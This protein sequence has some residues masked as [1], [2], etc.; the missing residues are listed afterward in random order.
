VHCW[1]ADF[2]DNSVLSQLNSTSTQ[3]QTNQLISNLIYVKKSDLTNPQNVL[4][5]TLP[6]PI[7]RIDLKSTLLDVT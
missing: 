4:T 1:E 6:F 7:Q 3:E 5:L 2:T